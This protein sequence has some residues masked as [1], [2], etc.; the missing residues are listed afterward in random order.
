[1]QVRSEVDEAYY[2]KLGG[3]RQIF[4]LFAVCVHAFLISLNYIDV[5]QLK[6]Q[7]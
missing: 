6:G 3:K 7:L 5:M 2:L 4:T 1:M